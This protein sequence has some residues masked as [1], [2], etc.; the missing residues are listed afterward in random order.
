M[1]RADGLVRG[2]GQVLGGFGEGERIVMK[3][4]LIG[5]TTNMAITAFVAAGIMVTSSGARGAETIS[6]DVGGYFKAY[7]AAMRQDDGAR[8]SS[9]NRRGSGAAREGGIKFSGQAQPDNR[10]T[11]GFGHLPV[12]Q[13]R[14]DHL[15][16]PAHERL[17]VG[18]FLYAGELRGTRGERQ[19]R[20]DFRRRTR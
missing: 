19:L 17:S 18:H 8:E 10:L 3:N 6:V 7:L 20:R 11:V 5:T 13:C 4:K 1:Y 16:H 9:A 12:R 15:F 14:K 2:T